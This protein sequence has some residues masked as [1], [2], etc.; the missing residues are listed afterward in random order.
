MLLTSWAIGLLVTTLL[1]LFVTFRAAFTG[2]RVVRFWDQSADTPLQ[3]RLEGEIWLS[4]S[5]MEYGLFLQIFSLFLLIIAADSFAPML[6]GAMCATGSFLANT[7]G[8]KALGLKLISV[9]FYGFW[10]VLHRLD[11]KS[12]LY[13]LVRVKYIYLLFL[14]PLLL[15]DISFQTLFLKG[16]HPDIIT[17][18]CG[19][20]F[21]EPTAGI[22]GLSREMASSTT[23]LIFYGACVLLFL[24]AWREFPFSRFLTVI[25][26][27][28][29]FP[30]G[31]WIVTTYISPYVYAMPHHRCP[32]CL[33]HSEYLF[34]G[35][36]L[37][38]SLYLA[39]FSGMASALPALFAS[40]RDLQPAISRF[41]NGFRL[42]LLVSLVVFTALSL[43]YPAQYFMLG[44]E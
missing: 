34:I 6:P 26:S 44:G 35:Y 19:V 11:I 2:V 4:S 9:F 40:R 16:I 25:I 15:A 1:V 8:M 42:L 41:Q 12:P 20:V 13:P 38:I 32:F 31:L 39:S 30:T 5:L 18:C 37:F 28:F 3:I 17:S 7:Y 36:P 43:F 23:I 29:L 33:L 24:S 10:I 14:C 21:Q 27:C 22:T